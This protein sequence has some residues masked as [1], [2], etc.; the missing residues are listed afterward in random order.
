[1]TLDE[2]FKYDGQHICKSI[3]TQL[4]FRLGATEASDQYTVDMTVKVKVKA[5]GRASMFRKVEEERDPVRLKLYPLYISEAVDR[6][7]GNNTFYFSIL[8]KKYGTL[9]MKYTLK[10]L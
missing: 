7:Y 9:G 5:K 6:N 8:C 3:P 1:M 4:K 10:P 2:A